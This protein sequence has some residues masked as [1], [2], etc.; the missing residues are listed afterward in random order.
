[1][2]KYAGTAIKLKSSGFS[3]AI[4]VH[5]AA[6]I[7][8]LSQAIRQIGHHLPA[9]QVSPHFSFSIN[10]IFEDTLNVNLISF[11]ALNTAFLDVFK[12]AAHKTIVNLTGS[13]AQVPYPS[14]GYTA[15]A[16]ASRQMALNILAKEEKDVKVCNGM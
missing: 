6:V 10:C 2:I 7:G 8:N 1:V 14:F 15:M 9:F 5:N 3:N 4:L 16:K 13:S 12:A 11:L